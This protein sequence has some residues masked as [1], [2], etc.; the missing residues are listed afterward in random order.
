MEQAA[1]R[2][3]QST[4]DRLLGLAVTLATGVAIFVV[5][6]PAIAIPLLFLLLLVIV[7]PATEVL[8]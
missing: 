1:V 2:M 3:Y 7:V 6:V 4:A 5:Q 8:V